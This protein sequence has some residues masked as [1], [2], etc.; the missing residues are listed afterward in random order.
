MHL[1]IHLVISFT[2]GLLMEMGLRMSFKEI[3]VLAKAFFLQLFAVMIRAGWV[4][5]CQFPVCPVLWLPFTGFCTSK[6][7]EGSTTPE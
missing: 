4:W 1:L 6:N 5:M 7:T 2:L 3:C